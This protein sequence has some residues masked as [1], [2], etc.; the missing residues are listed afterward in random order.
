MERQLGR[1]F[2]GACPP[3]R[4]CAHNPHT[5]A[6]P[7]PPS[8]PTRTRAEGEGDLLDDFVLHATA[9]AAEQDAAAGDADGALD[10]AESVPADSEEEESSEEGS[11]GAGG[12]GWE[13]GSGA[14]SLAGGSARAPARPG[15]IAST[16]WREER[17]DRRNLLT[18][19]D[20][21]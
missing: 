20:E 9:A 10:G 5:L 3:A 7:S 4:L 6:V 12:G 21:R 2:G 17:T 11:G 15:S 19:V 14:A 8:P 1:A 16:Y 13:R 18:V